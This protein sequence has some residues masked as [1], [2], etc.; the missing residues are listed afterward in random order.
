MPF[1]RLQF[2]IGMAVLIIPDGT[3]FLRFVVACD[4]V[5]A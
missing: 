5:P 2:L 4:E 1:G 3:G